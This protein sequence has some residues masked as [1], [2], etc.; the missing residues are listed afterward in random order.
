MA[1]QY[2]FYKKKS[3]YQYN[4]KLGS[5]KDLSVPII[6]KDIYRIDA[7]QEIKKQSDDDI[8]KELEIENYIS[9]LKEFI[10]TFEA[11]ISNNLKANKI[12][13]QEDIQS[14]LKAMI[15]NTIII[16]D[17]TPQI[18]TDQP[19][20]NC[21]GWSLGVSKWVELDQITPK[22]FIQKII[23]QKIVD[24]ILY[25]NYITDNTN[26]FFASNY[27]GLKLKA[28]L[29]PNQMKDGNIVAYYNNDTL[30]HTAR[31]TETTDWY[32]YD[33]ELH[34]DWYDKSKFDENGKYII[35][36]Y[37]S[38]LGVGYLAIHNVADICPLYGNHM[39]Y[40]ELEDL[41]S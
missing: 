39:E 17:S 22:N 11:K 3:F 10:G 38:K 32:K 34:E 18:I 40:Y 36:N 13:P 30:M 4:K 6:M 35:E 14:K 26:T 5:A 19:I 41:P 24:T 33:T 12:I 31:Y 23:E 1:K 25:P 2:N 9:F 20:Y 28:D 27:N 21:H 29:D 16:G 8:Y 15:D 7:L 37:V